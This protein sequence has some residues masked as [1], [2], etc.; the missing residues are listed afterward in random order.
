MSKREGALIS[1]TI[2]SVKKF[3]NRI[4]DR[5]TTKVKTVLLEH[6]VSDRMKAEVREAARVSIRERL[7]DADIRVKQQKPKIKEKSVLKERI[8]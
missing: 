3:L 7:L 1:S 4:T 2:N 8:R 5:I 6:S